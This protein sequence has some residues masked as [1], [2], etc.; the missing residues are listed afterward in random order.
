MSRPRQRHATIEEMLQ[1]VFF[2][3]L[4]QVYMTR[5][6]EFSSASVC[7]VWTELSCAEWSELVGEQLVREQLQ[8]SRCELLLLEAGSWD[9][10]IVQE[11][12][13]GRMSAI[14][15]CYQTTTGEDT[16]DW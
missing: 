3:G 6:A 7:N 13:V 14:G 2:V 11:P 1:V 4:L 15:S 8:F 10:G 5:P 16:A 9:T 12:R